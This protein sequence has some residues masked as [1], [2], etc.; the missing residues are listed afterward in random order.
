MQRTPFVLKTG[1]AL[2]RPLFPAS[3]R[4]PVLGALLLAALP[5]TALGQSLNTNSLNTNS[6][7]LAEPMSITQPNL[8]LTNPTRIV[9]PTVTQTLVP[10]RTQIAPNL[11]PSALPS[12][13][14]TR[15]APAIA[16]PATPSI[17][18]AP[19]APL[20]AAANGLGR[21]VAPGTENSN[22]VV[23]RIGSTARADVSS[24]TVDFDGD[25]LI[26]FEIAPGIVDVTA[27]APERGGSALD[28]LVGQHVSMATNTANRVLD[29]VINVEGVVAATTFEINNGTVVL[30]GVRPT[31][32][33]G[34]VDNGP[35]PNRP[36]PGVPSHDPNGDQGHGP[37]KPTGGHGDP[38]DNG[39]R[40]TDDVVI[41]LSHGCYGG[42]LSAPK[43]DD[44]PGANNG[45]A[46]DSE[47]ALDG[48]F[49]FTS[50]RAPP[51]PE[52]GT[53]SAPGDL[54]DVSILM[55]LR[56]REP[57]GDQFSNYGNEEIW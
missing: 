21:L 22:V 35:A 5:A 41:C 20:S 16:G 1:T 7:R 24:L 50:L 9:T 23:A 57:E 27:E 56:D 36:E 37:D 26:N 8:R 19:G 44:R 49:H 10:S 46:P 42:E 29:S 43:P 39:T 31:A 33:A 25:G 13:Q 15:V 28:G 4:M 34:L 45:T 40:P 18:V 51:T 2:W 52:S 12:I 38:A 6:L 47:P 54:V 55:P 48:L 14:S 3:V 32:V 11:A 53:E 17:G 30:G